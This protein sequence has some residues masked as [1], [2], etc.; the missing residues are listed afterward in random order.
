[1]HII[2]NRKLILMTLLVGGLSFVGM[3]ENGSGLLFS[4][5]GGENW[6]FPTKGLSIRPEG[7]RLLVSQPG[8]E[9]VEIALSQLATIGF[10]DQLSGVSLQKVEENGEV[11]VFTMQGI[12]LGG[13]SSQREAAERLPAGLYLIKSQKRTSKLHIR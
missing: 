4:G 11:E 7:E 6:N 13:F 3:A 12:R 1:M 9:T 5:K 8:A 2:M 10:N